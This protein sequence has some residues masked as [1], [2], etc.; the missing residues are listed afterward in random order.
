MGKRR[1]GRVRQLGSGRWQARYPGPDGI[2]RPA[3]ETFASQKDAERWLTVKEGEILKGDWINPDDGKVTLA[4]YGAT[5]ITERP[6]LRPKT[7]ELYRYLLRKHLAPALGAV[8]IGD[9][10][11]GHVR[12]WRTNLL[13]AGV[14]AINRGQGVP[15]AQSDTQHGHR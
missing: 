4:E 2:D 6:G 8:P 7:V 3:P 5:W 11:P 13:A 15:A 10:Q 1:F 12:R 14:S 9:L